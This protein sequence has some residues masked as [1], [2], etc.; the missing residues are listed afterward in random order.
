MKDFEKQFK[1]LFNPPVPKS[2]FD[3][4]KP[5]RDLQ[6]RNKL[7]F[8][9]LDSL[10]P[11]RELQE[12]NK[13]IF[14]GL[15]L[16]LNKIIKNAL[17]PYNTLLKNSFITPPRI[18]LPAITALKSLNEG[19]A[20][21][22]A[23]AFLKRN[24]EISKLLQSS[25]LESFNT[26]NIL[27]CHFEEIQKMTRLSGIGVT[28]SLKMFDED[29]F[30]NVSS[31]INQFHTD[32]EFFQELL[33]DAED[34]RTNTYSIKAVINYLSVKAPEL[35][36]LE[37]AVFFLIA[38]IVQS[39]LQQ[40]W[41]DYI[42]GPNICIARSGCRIRVD[43]TTQSDIKTAVPNGEEILVLE[44]HGHWKKVFWKKD[45]GEVY[46]GWMYS[47]LMQWKYKKNIH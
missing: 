39:S 17:E 35:L 14:G 6:E 43:G 5:F 31:I 38:M 24:T 32:P 22:Y 15:D 41:R 12:R 13:L 36:T 20:F 23:D 46:E 28:A 26:K 42:V 40:F 11:F 27:G 3:S 33:K 10:K 21:N 34:E 7:L 44:D 9:G 1:H 8:G 45:T 29:L 18:E 16:G 2:L 30:K 47:S 25:L 19:F 37:K 4:M